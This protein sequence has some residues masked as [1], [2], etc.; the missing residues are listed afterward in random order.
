MNRRKQLQQ[1]YMEIKTEAG[2][3]RITNT[4]NGKVFIGVTKNFKT[5]NGVTFSLNMGSYMNKELQKEWKEFG[6]SAFTIDIVEHLK[7]QDSEYFD[8][9]DALKKL[10]Q[11]W[12]EQ[13]GS[14]GERGYNK[15]P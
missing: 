2:V 11:K 6:E 9:D 10:E 4:V 15:Q 14:Y 3:F 5:L 12:I 7:K 8:V 13:L 1:E